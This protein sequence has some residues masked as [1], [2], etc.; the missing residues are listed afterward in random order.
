MYNKI[1]FFTCSIFILAFSC[2]SNDDPII[3]NGNPIE[4]PEDPNPEE[5]AD[6][7]IVYEP[8]LFEDSY[9]MA[10]ENGGTKSYLLNKKGNKIKQW[11]FN[12]NLGQDIELL[13]NGQLLAMFKIDTPI[14]SFPGYGGII[15]LI[16]PDGSIDW[17]FE[18][19]SNNYITHHD[20]DRLPNGNVLFIAWE[21]I[22]TEVAQQNGVNGGANIF[23]ETLIEVNPETDEIVWEWHSWDHIVQEFDENLPNYG[24]VSENPQLININYNDASTSN[25]MHFN[26]L[27]YDEEKD[28]IYV[29]VNYYSEVWVIDHS[30]T[31]AEAS[32]HTGGNYDRGGDLLYRFGNPTT[33]NNPEGERIFFNCHFPNLIEGNAP[34]NGNML[35]YNNG[36]NLS[37]SSVVEIQL[38]EFSLTPNVNNEPNVVWSFTD[39]SLFSPFISGAVRLDNGNTLIC[40]GTYGFWEISP[41]GNVVWKYKGSNQE[42][43]WRCYNYLPNSEAIAN[44]GL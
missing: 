22:E 44:L 10:I 2:S 36:N 40:E 27:D 15:R 19:Y 34:G 7:V 39:S 17:E 43:F 26:G 13:D 24:I 23:T 9:V 3:S 32:E 12:D 20:L 38:P 18:Y 37:Q 1:L 6:N 14:I 25:L 35:V 16:N 29:T 4:N 21:R 33:Y 5:V 30:T 8:D 42:S 11:N 31:T 28:V 41:D